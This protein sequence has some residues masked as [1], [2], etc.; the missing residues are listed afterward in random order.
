[1]G[2]RDAAAEHVSLEEELLSK[3]AESCLVRG[4]DSWSTQAGSG[5]ASKTTAKCDYI[6]IPEWGT[7]PHTAWQH[8]PQGNNN[9]RLN[10]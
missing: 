3:G 1:M 6:R 4:S 7:R 10:Q 5:A 2:H 8:A 9:I